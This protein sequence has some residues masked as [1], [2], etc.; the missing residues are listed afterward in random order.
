MEAK[1]CDLKYTVEQSNLYEPIIKVP[2][3]KASITK[4]TKLMTETI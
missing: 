1:L 3:F 2:I 4:T